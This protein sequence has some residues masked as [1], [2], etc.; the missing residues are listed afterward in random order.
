MSTEGFIK[1]KDSHSQ[2][3]CWGADTCDLLHM[4]INNSLRWYH[5]FNLA[6]QL[7]CTWQANLKEHITVRVSRGK[8]YRCLCK[9]GVWGCL[10]ESECRKQ[11]QFIS[12]FRPYK[13]CERNNSP[14][15]W[16]SIWVCVCR[17]PLNFCF[18]MRWWFVGQTFPETSL[19]GTI[20][21]LSDARQT[22]EWPIKTY[23]GRAHFQDKSARDLLHYTSHGADAKVKFFSVVIYIVSF[24]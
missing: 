1:K 5:L 8:G 7:N 6:S 14:L 21:H 24:Y 9:R 17:L 4:R 20:D 13:W 11:R 12:N 15:M 2:A 10:Y 23:R 22:Q 3:V 18:I 19:S 16:K